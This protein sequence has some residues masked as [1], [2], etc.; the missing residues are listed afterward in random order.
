MIRC[1]KLFFLFVKVPS[2][3]TVVLFSAFEWRGAKPREGRY[4]NCCL[5]T[6]S[7]ESSIYWSS[8]YCVVEQGDGDQEFEPTAD[9]LVHDFDDEQTLAEE[10]AIASAG[11]EDPQNELNN[12]QKVMTFNK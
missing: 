9:M 6:F 4:V 11:G 12:L 7:A 10:E 8:F 5:Q 1:Q 2:S 3:K